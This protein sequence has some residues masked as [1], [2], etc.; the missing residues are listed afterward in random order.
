MQDAVKAMER[1]NMLNH[2][3]EAR[4]DLLSRTFG[5]FFSDE[6]VNELLNKPDG[7]SLGGPSQKC[8]HLK[9]KRKSPTSFHARHE[10]ESCRAFSA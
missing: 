6:V 7:L 9:K 3:L 5:M 2:Q 8:G 10:Q 1:I 4:N